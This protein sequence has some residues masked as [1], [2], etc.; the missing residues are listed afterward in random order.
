MY[1]GDCV[2][3]MY[4]TD[5]GKAIASESLPNWRGGARGHY[6]FSPQ[7]GKM[8]LSNAGRD[9][10]EKIYV[11]CMQQWA[12]RISAGDMI[13]MEIVGLNFAQAV[14]IKKALSEIPGVSSVNHNLTSGV[15]TFRIKA[16]MTGEALA[17]HLIDDAWMSMIEIEDVKMN[18]IQG[19]A[20]G[21]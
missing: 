5:T 15:A 19:K 2:V 4:Y 10:V 3:H 6:S 12:T 20:V 14:K 13:E 9:V 17:E 21:G 1:N 7:A 11:T 16:K 18:R 8:A